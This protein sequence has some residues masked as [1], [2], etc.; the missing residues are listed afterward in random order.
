MART[1][2]KVMT[3]TLRLFEAAAAA[4]AAAA[5]EAKATGRV[6]IDATMPT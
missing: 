2:T 5:E 6:N 3:R 1:L 4:A